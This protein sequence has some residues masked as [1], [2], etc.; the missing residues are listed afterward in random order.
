MFAGR[1]TVDD[2]ETVCATG[3]GTAAQALDVL[4]ALVDKSLVTKED[5]RRV[6]CYRLHETMREYASLKL[7]DAAEEEVLDESFVEYY[8]IR[9]LEAEDDA[10]HRTLEWLQWVELEIDNI[11]SALQK[12][13]A[14]SDWRRGLE[15]ATSIGYYWVTRGTTESMRWFDELLAAAAG[16]ADVPAR[17]YHFRGWLSMRQVDPE[18]ARPW[19][20][21]AIAAARA[22]GAALAAV[23]IAVDGRDGGEHGGRSRGRPTAPRRGRGPRPGAFIHYPAS[24]GL[25][26]AQS[27]P[28]VLRGRPRHR[29]R[30]PPS[31]GARLSR[32]AGDLYYLQYRCFMYLGQVAMLAGDVAASKPRFVE[33][34]RIARQIDDR[35][36]QYDLLSLLGWHAATLRAATPGGTTARGRG[37]R[38]I[39]C[40]RRHDGPG[41]ATPGAGQR[42]G[43]ERAGGI[44]VRGRVRGRQAHGPGSGTAHGA[45]RIRADRCRRLPIRLRPDHWRSGR[46][47]WRDWSP[48]A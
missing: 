18:A 43:G 40:G 27:H 12:C 37:G 6:A 41:H 3:E 25:I 32:E 44:E 45:E 33:A 16:S 21:R 28:R 23:R 39:R 15:L 2:A 34:L 38:R 47:R 17:A 20:A 4:S 31:D 14:T 26:Q 19:L 30:R 24:I 29:R 35:L 42:S 46:S 9:C 13:L 36:A 22:S 7:R 11:R 5:V 10:R 8:R 1:F 48:K